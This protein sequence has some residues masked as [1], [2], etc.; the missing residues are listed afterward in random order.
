MSM[1]EEAYG[2]CWVCGSKAILRYRVCFA[3]VMEE[4]AETDAQQTSAEEDI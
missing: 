3:C 4:D 2:C 1:N